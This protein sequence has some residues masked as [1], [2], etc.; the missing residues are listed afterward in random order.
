M[1]LPEVP[2]MD[3]WISRTVPGH[4]DWVETPKSVW[5]DAVA[6]F[7]RIVNW[8][9]RIVGSTL[10]FRLKWIQKHMMLFVMI[11]LF[12]V[13]KLGRWDHFGPSRAN[14]RSAQQELHP[15]TFPWA[16]LVMGWKDFSMSTQRWTFTLLVTQPSLCSEGRL[17]KMANFKN[18]YIRISFFFDST[19]F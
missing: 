7:L 9:L 8:G 6:L 2:V 3:T 4:E 5:L 17:I 15:F 16:E 12:L 19:N 10:I 13:I 18:F 1:F 11:L 14:Q